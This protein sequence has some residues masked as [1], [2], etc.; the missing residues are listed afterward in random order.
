MMSKFAEIRNDFVFENF[1]DIEGDL[2]AVI[3]IDTWLTDDDN[4][5]GAVVAQVAKTKSGDI[6]VI[7]NDN[8]VRADEEVTNAI[9]EAKNILKNLS[10]NY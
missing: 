9:I 8:S 6:I 3:P 2:E 10:K 4:E 7:Y 1:T 5:E